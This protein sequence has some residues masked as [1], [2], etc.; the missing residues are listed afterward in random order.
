MEGRMPCSGCLVQDEVDD[1]GGV[2]YVDH[3][4]AVEVGFGFVEWGAAC[5]ENV[6]DE[7]GHIAHVNHTVEVH[8]TMNWCTNGEIHEITPNVVARG[9]VWVAQHDAVGLPHF[10]SCERGV[11]L[12]FFSLALLD[13]HK[14]AEHA[15][16][17][18]VGA[19][20][21]C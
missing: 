6:V 9:V 21:H 1:G 7:G 19:L 20:G 18:A 4:V 3:A 17:Y 16:E 11:E 12:H 5:A 14:F 8:I 10:A 15:R 2:G 13:G